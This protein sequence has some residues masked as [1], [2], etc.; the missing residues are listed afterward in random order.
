ML[1]GK[2]ESAVEMC[3]SLRA[4]LVIP[5]KGPRKGCEELLGEIE[6]LLGAWVSCVFSFVCGTTLARQPKFQFQTSML[7]GRCQDEHV[8]W[9][10]PIWSLSRRACWLVQT[11][12]AVKTSMLV[13][14]DQHARLELKFRQLLKVL[15]RSG[16]P[17][18]DHWPEI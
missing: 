7:V 15:C 5:G 11:N 3:E 9:C 16:P 6:T 14:P 4:K 17:G 2:V 10:K 12:V 13:G 1:V 18:S 8:G